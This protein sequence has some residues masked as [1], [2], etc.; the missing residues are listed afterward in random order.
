MKV[1]IFSLV[2]L[3]LPNFWYYLFLFYVN[4]IS[5]IWS[6]W[7]FLIPNREKCQFHACIWRD[8]RY[9]NLGRRYDLQSLPEYLGELNELEEL[10]LQ[11]CH[12]LTTLAS[13]LERSRRIWILNLEGCC[14][15]TKLPKSL[16]EL[17]DYA[18]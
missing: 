12:S 7:I 13:S 2:F 16:E 9:L 17:V 8:L 15:S 11:Y 14:A 10:S 5:H 6:I 4:L 18:I 3:E 1:S